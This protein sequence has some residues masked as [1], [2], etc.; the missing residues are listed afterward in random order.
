MHKIFNSLIFNE[1]PV[2]SYL[3]VSIHA[4][5]SYEYVE[6]MGYMCRNRV[7][8]STGEMSRPSDKFAFI[9]N[10]VNDNDPGGRK[11]SGKCITVILISRARKPD[12]FPIKA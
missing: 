3:R 6:T 12:A 5:H 9:Q 11:L 4:F 8:A 7:H 10:F 1:R 2:L